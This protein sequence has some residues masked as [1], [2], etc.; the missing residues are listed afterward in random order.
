MLAALLLPAGSA[1]GDGFSGQR[2][3]PPIGAAGGFLVERPVVPLHLGFGVGLVAS[4][5]GSPVVLRDRA[6][7]AELGAPLRHALSLDVVGSLGLFGFLEVAVDLPVHALYLGDPLS[8]GGQTLS[9]DA[10]LGDLR[11]D[12]KVA[13][14]LRAR[15]LDLYLGGDLLLTFPTGDAAALRG[16]GGV[17]LE[18]RF[19]FGFG[20]PRWLVATSVGFRAR[21]GSMALDVTGAY[22][23]TYGVAATVGV[24]TGK[25]PLDLSAELAGGFQPSS[26]THAAP[27]ELLA[28]AVV[29]PHRE[30]AVYAAVGPGLTSGVGSPD[31]RA[32]IGVRWARH[33]PGRDHATDSDHDGVPDY[34]DYCPLAREDRDGFEDED[35]CPEIDNDHDG[36]ID[37]LDECPNQAEEP[38]GD[39]DGCPDKARVVIH[40]GKVVV[41]GKVR[42]AT[43]SARLLPGSLGLLDQIAGVMKEHPEI[44]RL[45]IEGH[46]DSQGDP[47]FN[48]RLSKARAEA[49]RQYLISRGV[50]EKRL[51]ARGLGPGQPLAPNDTPAGRAQN[52]RVEFEATRRR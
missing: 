31:V 11:L 15:P 34:R 38:G 6:S 13:W 39:G 2:Y 14:W 23:L 33:L 43:G 7:G 32:L 3:A 52:R 49:V 36:V 12:H 17:T 25:V 45:R 8:L 5:A 4:Y 40:R 37:D 51:Q 20:G 50:D 47:A 24:L 28:G 29:W 22:E 48:V 18:P 10:G 44:E 27:L 35:G 30:V 1:V 21:F 42:F 46:T 16:A 41:F 9:A 19:L 26:T